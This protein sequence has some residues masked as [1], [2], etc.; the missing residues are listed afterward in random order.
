MKKKKNKK[1]SRDR[2]IKD[3]KVHKKK[4]NNF[5][6]KILKKKNKNSQINNRYVAAAL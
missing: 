3:M 1:V 5:F 2:A 4:K 6:F